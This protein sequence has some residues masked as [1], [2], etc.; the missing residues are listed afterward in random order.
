MGALG[1]AKAQVCDFWVSAYES[2]YYDAMCCHMDF[3]QYMI[4]FAFALLVM[5]SHIEKLQGAGAEMTGTSI[6]NH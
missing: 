5:V 4:V 1:E 6:C 3:C 2:N